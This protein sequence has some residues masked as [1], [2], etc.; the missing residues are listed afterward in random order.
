MKKYIPDLFMTAGAGAISYGAYMVYPAAGV[1]IA[2]VLVLA[3]GLKMA[4]IS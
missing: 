3:A 1:V 2:G 4:A